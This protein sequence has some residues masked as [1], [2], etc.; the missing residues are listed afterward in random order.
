MMRSA[1]RTRCRVATMGAGNHVI[2]Q[3]LFASGILMLY[4]QRF[5]LCDTRKPFS[6]IRSMGG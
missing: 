1:C 3:N 4:P 6:V 2:K 5:W